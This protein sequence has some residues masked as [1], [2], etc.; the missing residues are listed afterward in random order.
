MIARPGWVLGVEPTWFVAGAGV[1]GFVRAKG[2]S[3]FRPCR[4]FDGGSVRALSIAGP[5]MQPEQRV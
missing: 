3:L 2:F 4:A 5:E 1:E